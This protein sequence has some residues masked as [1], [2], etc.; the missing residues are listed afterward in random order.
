MFL[1]NKGK[2]STLFMM[3]QK[4]PPMGNINL[5]YQSQFGSIYQK[6]EHD[7][8][9]VREKERRKMREF[10]GLIE[11]FWIDCRTKCILH[12]NSRISALVLNIITNQMCK[13]H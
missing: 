3:C 11:T 5:K 6:K 2:Y 7:L 10:Y 4:L 13:F 12:G 8:F 9:N 1:N